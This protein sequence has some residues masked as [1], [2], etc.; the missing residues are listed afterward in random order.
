[1]ASTWKVR[2]T[3]ELSKGNKRKG[4]HHWYHIKGFRFPWPVCDNCGLVG[5]KNE[6]TRKA[7]KAQCEWEEDA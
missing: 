1:M 5:L 6:A 4:T 3:N 7:I 2:Q